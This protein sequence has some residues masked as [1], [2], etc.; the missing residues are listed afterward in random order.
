MWVFIGYP[1]HIFLANFS[2]TKRHL[3]DFYDIEKYMMKKKLNIELKKIRL[4]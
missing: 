2:A 3:G 4:A 1:V